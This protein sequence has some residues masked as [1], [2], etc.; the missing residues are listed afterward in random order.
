MT[1]EKMLGLMQQTAAKNGQDAKSE[2]KS[3]SSK[4]AKKH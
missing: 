4:K 3:V 2:Q 1:I